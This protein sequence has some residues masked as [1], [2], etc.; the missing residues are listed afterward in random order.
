MTAADKN[1]ESRAKRALEAFRG[2][3]VIHFYDL[4]SGIGR[5]T[6]ALLVERGLVQVV[7][8]DVGIYSKDYVWRL[9]RR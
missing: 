9:V 4:P 5:K 1:L 3:E 6:M 2:L 8:T 7:D